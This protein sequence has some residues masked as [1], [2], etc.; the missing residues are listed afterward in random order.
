MKATKR[1]SIKNRSVFAWSLIIVGGLLVTFSGVIGVGFGRKDEPM[2]RALYGV[3]DQVREIS[4]MVTTAGYL[5]FAV[6]LV[7]RLSIA[8]SGLA[9][10][11]YKKEIEVTDRASDN[12]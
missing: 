5:L 9:S 7:E 4:W 12:H 6:G 11:M 8:V 1:S 3:N 2:S 10:Q